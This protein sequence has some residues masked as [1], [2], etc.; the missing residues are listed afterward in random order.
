MIAIWT[1]RFCLHATDHPVVPKSPY[2]MSPID[3]PPNDK[4]KAKAKKSSESKETSTPPASP[5]SAS[6]APASAPQSGSDY[7]VSKPR[8][9]VGSRGKQT[10]ATSGQS[11]STTPRSAGSSLSTVSGGQTLSK[12]PSP[13]NS[14]TEYATSPTE[15]PSGAGESGGQTPRGGPRRTSVAAG[16]PSSDEQATSYAM[17]QVEDDDT[18]SSESEN[19]SAESDSEDQ[20][21]KTAPPLS[22][23]KASARHA[24]V[25]PPQRDRITQGNSG[26]STGSA[27]NSGWTEARR[28]QALSSGES[29]LPVI[30]GAFRSGTNAEVLSP[31]RVAVSSP[32]STSDSIDSVSGTKM[33][34]SSSGI[35]RPITAGIHQKRSAAPTEDSDTTDSDDESDSDGQVLTQEDEGAMTWNEAFQRA[36]DLPETNDTVK[37]EKMEMIAK[38]AQDFVST[39]QLFGRIIISEV[40][41]SNDNKTFKPSVAAGG[42]AGGEKYILNGILFKFAV[43]W[44]GIYTS[45]EYAMKA[46]SHELKGLEQFLDFSPGVRVPL[47][48]LIDYLGFRLIALSLLPIDGSTLVYGSD[49]AGHTVSSTDPEGNMKKAGEILKLK[50]HVAGQ[51]ESFTAQVSFP[52]DIEGHLGADNRF[53][54]LDLAR[55]MPPTA[56]DKGKVASQYLF[57]LFRPE[58]LRNYRCPLS[59]DAFSN[60]EKCDPHREVHRKEIVEAT[61]GLH[62]MIVRHVT[63]MESTCTFTDKTKPQQFIDLLH[64]A[65]INI[66]YL[67]LVRTR[68][69]PYLKTFVMLEMIARGIKTHL[70]EVLR[71]AVR[72]QMT[73]ALQPLRAA[74]VDQF[75]IM[76]GNA[77]DRKRESTAFWSALHT[78]LMV[79]F[80]GFPSTEALRRELQRDLAGIFLINGVC[81]SSKHLQEDM[82]PMISYECLTCAIL[83]PQGVCAVCAQNCHATHTLSKPKWR[84]STFCSCDSPKCCRSFAMGQLSTAD[85]PLK[86]FAEIVGIGRIFERAADLAG[87][88]ISKGARGELRNNPHQFVFVLPDIKDLVLK[89]KQLTITT[90]AEAKSLHLAARNR[91]HYERLRMFHQC[92]NLF[93]KT[94]KMSPGA[95]R[96]RVEFLGILYEQLTLSRESSVDDL[97]LTK[98]VQL[99]QELRDSKVA[100][101]VITSLST[102]TLEVLNRASESLQVCFS[103]V[104]EQGIALKTTERLEILEFISQFG[105]QLIS[106]DL[107]QTGYSTLLDDEILT[108]LSDRCVKLQ[109]L[110]L[111]Y[112]PRR[113]SESCLGRVATGWKNLRHIDLSSSSVNDNVI[114]TFAVTCPYIRTLDISSC[115]QLTDAS[116]RH[117]SKL[118]ELSVLNLSYTELTEVGALSTCEH[119]EL[120][121]M[122]SCKIWIAQFRRL[123]SPIGKSTGSLKVLDISYCT[124]D[125][126]TIIGEI[127]SLCTDLQHL[128]LDGWHIS[129]EFLIKEPP[130]KLHHISIKGWQIHQSTLEYFKTFK[131]KVD[132]DNGDSILPG[133]MPVSA[134]PKDKTN[135]IMQTINHLASRSTRQ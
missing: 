95:R 119:L 44:K 76:L 38:I 52:A 14:S 34:A 103:I 57:R 58:F 21:P 83:Y 96:L 59:P 91:T 20:Q 105:S 10:S 66:R 51:R 108:K 73:M 132:M 6:K 64:K 93:E 78:K 61:Q 122:R 79:Q 45:D 50:E 77:P 130:K 113:V 4:G 33:G 65:G 3:E 43:D 26:S 81:T 114:C 97:I 107:G 131:V 99:C 2:L 92:N 88:V 118:V 126:P 70:R 40:F 16:T 133:E 32:S 123:L 68:T 80:D 112:N 49:N 110:K 129:E 39:A 36:I 25:E 115:P 24:S 124:P 94:L 71:S 22:L 17:A 9:M 8:F 102:Q 106:L 121:T 19:T 134:A 85:H 128:H 30:M 125:T 109:Q 127:M 72:E 15:K 27:G 87:V 29:D 48:C 18:S 117:I 100:R 120:L 62:E 47:I 7:V 101:D 31:R 82:P 60:F 74:V 116:L 67:P 63:T 111:N 11:E 37:L 56:P 5:S 23:F 46:A 69:G 135:F 42:N 75:N 35:R 54:V 13:P 84:S 98:C 1:A 89:S 53:Y 28:P 12:T 55:L 86:H 104:L 41:L 90:L